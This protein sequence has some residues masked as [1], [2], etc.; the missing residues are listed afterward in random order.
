MGWVLQSIEARRKVGA[1]EN[2]TKKKLEIRKI[3]EESFKK[4]HQAG[5]KLACGTDLSVDPGVGENAY[6]LEL[7]VEFGMTPMEAIM[8]ATKN[9]GEAIGMG[10][11]CAE[12]VEREVAGDHP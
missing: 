7:Y 5:V 9:A 4:L 12:E 10:S 1:P 11:V 8:T 2:V 6:E 3:C